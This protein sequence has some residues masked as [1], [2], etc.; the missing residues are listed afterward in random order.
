MKRVMFIFLM[1]GSIT[2]CGLQ[3]YGQIVTEEKK[4]EKLDQL[5]NEVRYRSSVRYVVVY[6]DI[7]E[8]NTREIEIL[9]DEKQFN[10][11]S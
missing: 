8:R 5:D 11:K 10:E 7:S 2:I 3:I 9:M 6:D 1:F 4:R